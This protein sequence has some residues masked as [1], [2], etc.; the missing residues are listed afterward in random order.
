MNEKHPMGVLHSF[1]IKNNFYDKMDLRLFYFHVT[2]W[3]LLLSHA[4]PEKCCKAQK[5]SIF[6]SYKS[7][8]KIQKELT[9]KNSTVRA[10]CISESCINIK[11][12]LKFLFLHFFVVP[13][14]VLWRLLRPSWNLL[15]KRKEV[16][17]WKFK[18]TFSLHL[19]SGQEGLKAH[20]STS[21]CLYLSLKLTAEAALQ[22]CFQN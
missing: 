4:F 3:S 15:W 19:G 13:Q 17:K 8:I 7:D 10:P 2:I 14:T 16:W 18:L 12:N 6:L 20:L 11:M 1:S 9:L 22:C 21:S 5:C